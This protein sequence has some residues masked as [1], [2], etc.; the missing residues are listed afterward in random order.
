MAPAS[1]PARPASSPRRSGDRHAGCRSRRGR[2]G[3]AARRRG[4]RSPTAG[5]RCIRGP[6][7]MLA[8]TSRW[9]NSCSSW[10][11]IPMLRRCAGRWVMSIAIER[12]HAGI[13]QPADRRSTRSSVLLPA[14]DGPSTATISP[15]ST[16]SDEPVEHDAF[17]E[18]H[19][20]RR[21]RQASS[22]P[23]RSWLPEAITIT[24]VNTNR[25]VAIANAWARG[26]APARPSK[27]PIAI[28]SVSLPERLRIVVAPNSPSEIAAENPA[29]ASSGRRKRA[30]VDLPP[31]PDRRRPQ[32]GRGGAQVARGSPAARRAGAHDERHGDQRVAEG[33]EPPSRPPVDRRRVEGDQHAETDGDCRRAERQHQSGVEQLAES[34]RA[35]D[36]GGGEESDRRGDQRRPRL[37]IAAMRQWPRADRHRAQ[38]PGAPRLGRA[39]STPTATSRCRRLNDRL[40]RATSGAP[41]ATATAAPTRADEHSLS[42]ATRP[43]AARWRRSI[44]SPCD[45]AVATSTRSPRRAIRAAPPTRQ[46]R[47]RHRRAVWPVGRS[48][49]R[50]SGC[51]GPPSSLATP[52]EVKL[53]RKITAAADH[54]AGRSS[55][56]MINLRGAGRRGTQACVRRRRGRGGSRRSSTRPGERPRRC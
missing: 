44:R 55:G 16:C 32:R 19:R 8:A 27:R 45:A 39:C 20:R 41:T 5:Q 1:G 21:R 40:T 4:R 46:R 2:R 10:N 12:H 3:R 6:K 38:R 53:N 9:G 43:S 56:S 42:A 52:N 17:P 13:G 36:R 51:V 33:D 28:G 48:R 50:A 37:R 49:P 7:A 31:R 47:R 23:R 34:R 14:P 11:I 26:S 22:E 29:P 15:S 30:G 18:P 24:V 54:S 25:I 35:V